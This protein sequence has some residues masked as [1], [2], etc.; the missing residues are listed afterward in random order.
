MPVPVLRYPSVSSGNCF[1][2][3]TTEEEPKQ[4]K[5]SFLAEMH[6]QIFI[7][8]CAVDINQKEKETNK[9]ELTA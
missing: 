1:L 4:K 3:E 2:V 8:I 9:R 5:A 7:D 6:I